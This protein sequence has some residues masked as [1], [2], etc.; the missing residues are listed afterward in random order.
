MTQIH[1][2]VPERL[3]VAYAS[4]S[5][6]HAFS[7]V[8]AAHVSLCEDCRAALEAHYAVGGSLLDDGEIADLSDGIKTDLLARLDAPEVPQP[9]YRRKGPLPG[10]VVAALG[11]RAPRWRSLGL[12]VKQDII[13][14]GDEGSVRLLSIPP[15]QSVPD[16]SHGGMELTLVL[17]GSFSDATGEYRVGDLEIADEDLEHTPVATE[18][19]TCICLAATD[20]PLQFRSLVPR[21]LQPIFR[22]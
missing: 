22:I 21:I 7:L 18:G 10:P 13:A 14:S 5:L 6:N 1:H 20:A 11:G 8:V 16:H 3:L 19:E 2:H 9:I 4:G 15:G 12:G 17:Q